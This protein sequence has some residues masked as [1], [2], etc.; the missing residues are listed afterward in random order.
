MKQQKTSTER[1]GAGTDAGMDTTATTATTAVEVDTTATE[2]TA[3]AEIINEVKA[4][5]ADMRITNALIA[6]AAT[7]RVGTITAIS[8]A[9]TA[10][11]TE[12]TGTEANDNAITDKDR[13][14]IDK[15]LKRLFNLPPSDHLY[16]LVNMPK[17]L[18]VYRLLDDAHERGNWQASA[19]NLELTQPAR[20]APRPQNII[21]MDSGQSEKS[22]RKARKAGVSNGKANKTD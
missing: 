20:W 22:F 17:T 9:N 10:T 7:A 19:L 15:W 18:R 4:M 14:K 13:R 11:G 3:N 6:A 1:K 12:A 21:F 5:L 2:P 16:V 8:E